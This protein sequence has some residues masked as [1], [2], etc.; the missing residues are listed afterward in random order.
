MIKKRKNV[1]IT[2]CDPPSS[3]CDSS[4]FE[5]KKVVNTLQVKVGEYVDE[6]LVK[7][8]IKDNENWTIEFVRQI[9]GVQPNGR[10]K[11][12]KFLSAQEETSKV[13]SLKFG[14]GLT[15]NTEPSIAI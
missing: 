14:E 13:E 15:A 6:E 10:G 1:K 9:V 8:W 11:G 5:V 3:I 7:R 12:L 2:L 4:A